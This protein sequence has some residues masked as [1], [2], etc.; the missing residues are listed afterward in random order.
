MMIGFED[1][2]GFKHVTPPDI[3]ILHKFTISFLGLYKEQKWMFTMEII[4]HITNVA[5]KSFLL[6]K[7]DME[8]GVVSGME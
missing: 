4:N 3:W 6:S 5:G 2:A 1:K 7:V 8:G